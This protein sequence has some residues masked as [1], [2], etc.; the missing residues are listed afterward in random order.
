M[1]KL[2]GR[3]IVLPYYAGQNVT[4]IKNKILKNWVHSPE[5]EGG[6]HDKS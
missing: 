3:V 5:S 6:K 1:N 2:K 4:S